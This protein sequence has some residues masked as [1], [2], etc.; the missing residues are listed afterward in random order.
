M[1]RLKLTVE[2]YHSPQARK[3]YLSASRYKDYAGSLGIV[4]CEARALALERGEWEEAPTPSM[5]MSSFVDAHFSGNLGAFKSQNP[6]IFTKQGELK[7]QYKDAE[8]I[9]QR[10]ERDPYFMK[11]MSGQKQVIMTAELFGA[12]WSCMIDSFI[13]DVAIVD[14]KVMADLRKAF[15][16]KDWGN[17]SFIQFWGYIE[18]AAIYQAV[19]EKNTGKQLPFYIAAA[20]KEDE[21]DLEIIAFDQNSIDEILTVIERNV[22]RI[23]DVKSGKVT[24]D[25]CGQCDYCRKTKVLHEPIHYSDLILKP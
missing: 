25:R 12:R 4:P 1:G 5:L 24:P 16:V 11:Y 2:N 22:L 20:S 10:I 8:K 3:E 23:L 19:V 15:W 21:P 13:P 14:L 18:Q 6:D 9:I 7:A 17:M